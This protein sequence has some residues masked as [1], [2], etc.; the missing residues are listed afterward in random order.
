MAS[1]HDHAVGRR[2]PHREMARTDLTQ[3]QRIVQRQ[4]MRDAGLIKLGRHDPDIIRQR[5]GDLLHDLEAG[6]M[7]AVIIGA[8]NSH[9]FPCL[10]RVHSAPLD[11][12]LYP[13]GTI[14]ANPVDQTSNSRESARSTSNAY[15]PRPH[16]SGR[17]ALN[18]HFEI[19]SHRLRRGG[20]L[21][22]AQLLR[23][24]LFRFRYTLLARLGLVGRIRKM[25]AR[26]LKRLVEVLAVDSVHGADV[27]Q[28][29]LFLP[30]RRSAGKH[31]RD[32]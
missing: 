9:P 10:F 11:V 16:E 26:D 30:T 2:A 8:E 14:E 1:P 29:L 12:R 21:A 7:D 3:S 23:V 17:P 5:T 27:F 6:S 13:S 32:E 22:G 18:M 24:G 20:N 25:L 19:P 28:D 15:S 31:P 4:R